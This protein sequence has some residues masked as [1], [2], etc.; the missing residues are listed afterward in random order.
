MYMPSSI[1]NNLFSFIFF[2]YSFIHLNSLGRS[3][4][5]VLKYCIITIVSC[6]N[7]VNKTTLKERRKKKYIYNKM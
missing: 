7:Y 1:E 6:S 3:G 4:K 5:I 2:I